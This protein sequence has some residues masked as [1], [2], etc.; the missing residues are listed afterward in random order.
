MPDLVLN[1]GLLVI[2]VLA[3]FL[4]VLAGGGSVLVFAGLI[5]MGVSPVVANATIRVGLVGQGLLAVCAFRKND[6]SC[7]REG[8]VIGLAAIP[9][10]VAGAFLAVG[11]SEQSIKS[12]LAFVMCFVVVSILLPKGQNAEED[13]KASLNISPW[14]YPLIFLAGCYGG[15]IQAG[16]G[17]LI[18]SI[19]AYFTNANMLK[20]NVIKVTTVLVY[21]IPVIAVFSYFG[22]INW[23]YGFLLFIGYGL[24]GWLGASWSIGRD[25]KVIRIIVAVVISVMAIKLVAG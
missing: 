20:T 9:G 11:I 19:L 13:E 5:F 15:F 12:C 1:I 24:G 7:L 21:N 8:L 25:D 3:G 22:I 16:V 17:F 6:V 4:N 18:M 23:L 14:T 10:A 2:G